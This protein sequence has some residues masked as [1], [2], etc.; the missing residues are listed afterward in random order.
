MLLRIFERSPQKRHRIS[1]KSWPK[2]NRSRRLLPRGERRKPI[3]LLRRR[4]KRRLQLTR[5]SGG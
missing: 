1:K 3:S 5:R 2:K 4:S